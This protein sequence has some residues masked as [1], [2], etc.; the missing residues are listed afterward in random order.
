MLSGGYIAG[1]L[2][3]RI[4]L[5]THRQTNE[6]FIQ[7]APVADFIVLSLILI[8]GLVTIF[9]AQFVAPYK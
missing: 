1:Y 3:I 8:I 6:L 7:N 4:I 9:F 2:I 5:E